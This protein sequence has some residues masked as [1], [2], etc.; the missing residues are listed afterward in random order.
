MDSFAQYGKK[1]L[2]SDPLTERKSIFWSPSRKKI[3]CN[4]GNLFPKLHNIRLSDPLA[5]KKSCATREIFFPGCTIYYFLLAVHKVD[6]IAQCGAKIV[7]FLTPLQK[8]KSRETREIFFPSCTIYYFILAVHKVDFIAQYG[9]KNLF[10]DL[11]A[12]TKSIFWS[13]SRKKSCATRDIFFPSCTIYYFLLAIHKV[14]F[15]AQYG[16]KK[17]IFWP[18]SRKEIYFLI[19]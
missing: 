4:A 19:P 9:G 16:A 15:N 12:E 8:K 11:L 14:D 2:I 18:S 17:S 6:F 5:E 10:S 3:V 13:P 7:Y 1:K